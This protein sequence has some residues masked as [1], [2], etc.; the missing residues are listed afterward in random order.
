MTEKEE[1]VFFSK[2]ANLRRKEK[3]VS[4]RIESTIND[5]LF[6]EIGD[7][8]E[9]R[10]KIITL[11]LFIEYWLNK[12]LEKIFDNENITKNYNNFYGKLNELN[13][14]GVLDKT[15]FFNINSINKIRNKYAHELEIEKIQTQINELINS[16]IIRPDYETNDADKF[17]Y[18][19]V[20]TMMDL[21]EIYHRAEKI[22]LPIL[23]E[24]ESDN[25]TDEKFR[26]QLIDEGSLYW[27]YCKILD[28]EKI[29]YIT[30][31]VLKCPYCLVGKIIRER[32]DTPGFKESEICPCD[33]CGL[34]GESTEL[35]YETIKKK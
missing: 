6:S 15:L 31:Y 1:P 22:K 21:E 19:V 4:V 27:Q 10:N 35:K 25:L 28:T 17:R 12:I 32:D 5:R 8:K 13:N 29:G 20:Q 18:I 24:L 14:L 16:L 26:K 23:F 3:N 30:R 9:Q 2:L 34:H 7:I 33:N 11:H